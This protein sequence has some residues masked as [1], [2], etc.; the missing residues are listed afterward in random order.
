MQEGFTEKPH[1]RDCRAACLTAGLGDKFG[2]E[3]LVAVLLAHDGGLQEGGSFIH[4][5][6]VLGG[7]AHQVGE[8]LQ[9]FLTRLLIAFNNL[10]THKD[11]GMNPLV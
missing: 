10:D 4:V 6:E 1:S 5:M 3:A 11:T 7:A 9:R 2:Q 8:D